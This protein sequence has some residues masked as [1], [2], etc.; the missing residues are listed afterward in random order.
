[1]FDF[2]FFKAGQTQVTLLQYLAT[3]LILQVKQLIRIESLDQFGS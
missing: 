1:M 3:M 2:F